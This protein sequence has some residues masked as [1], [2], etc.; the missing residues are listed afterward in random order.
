MR[1]LSA[2]ACH[3]TCVFSVYVPTWV[4][5]RA[6]VSVCATSH[7][8]SISHIVGR[9]PHNPQHSRCSESV[10]QF[11]RIVQGGILRRVHCSSVSSLAHLCVVC[12]CAM[13]V[14][15]YVYVR[16]CV[17]I[18]VCACVC[19]RVCVCVWQSGQVVPVLRVCVR[20]RTCVRAC[21][22]VHAKIRARATKNATPVRISF[23]HHRPPPFL[24]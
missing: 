24:S 20:V 22:C 1:G 7:V 6:C 12:L 2:C 11:Y 17:C 10:P 4:R 3:C 8:R 5:S 13:C 23:V 14:Y 9:S 21:A 19:V 16:A 18:Y 15:A